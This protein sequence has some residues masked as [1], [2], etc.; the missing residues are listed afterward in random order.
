MGSKTGIEWTD[1]TWNPL[2]HRSTWTGRV[3]L[4]EKHLL[5]P[6]KWRPVIEHTEACTLKETKIKLCQC[7]TRP[8]RIFVN[9]MSDLFHEKVPDEW[10]DRIIAIGILSG[11]ILQILTKR[12]E[13]MLAYF[14]GSC[15]RSWCQR[16]SQAIYDEIHE[17]GHHW[18][19]GLLDIVNRRA[20]TASALV[21]KG[22]PLSNFW[23]GVSVEN[24]AAVDE[25]IPLLLQTPAAMRFVSCEP[26]LGPVDLSCI[27]WP[28]GFPFSIDGPGSDGFDAL[29][30]DDRNSL[31]KLPHLDWVI[32]GGESGPGARPMHPEW[33]LSLRDQCAAAGVPFFFKQWGEWLPWNTI[34]E[35]IEH[36]HPST[37][38]LVKAGGRV[39]RPFC[40]EDRP[41]QKMVR[42]GRE[43]AGA[44]LDGC[45]HKAFPE[46]RA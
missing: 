36:L 40:Y 17:K 42:V 13:R 6:L 26:L 3:N 39:I 9:S 30:F 45:T 44:L 23:L 37:I 33:A 32:A 15:R 20:N 16:V 1:S 12:A 43:D 19:Q 38:C 8:R 46:V 7:P 34:S 21:L 18:N 31:A 28:T 22:N 35:L 14:A 11:H 41:G 2:A 24:Q 29:R 5:D 25:R 10:I 4:A 27:P